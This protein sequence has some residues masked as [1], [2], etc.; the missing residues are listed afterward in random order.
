MNSKE[1]TSVDLIMKQLAAELG[2]EKQNSKKIDK[3][4][5]ELDKALGT[6]LVDEGFDQIE[7]ENE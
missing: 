1:K 7:E 6:T 4:N 2:K 3:L 5:A